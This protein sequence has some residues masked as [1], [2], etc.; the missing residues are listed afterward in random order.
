MLN[1]LDELK[2][3]LEKN[4]LLK[5]EISLNESYKRAI[6]IPEVLKIL[7]LE[8]P[9]VTDLSETLG[10]KLISVMAIRMDLNKRVD[11]HKKFVVAGLI[12]RG[13]LMGLIPN[14]KRDTLIDGGNFNS[15]SALKFYAKRFGMKGMYVMSYLFPDHII[16][17]LEG[18]DFTV[19]K[20]PHQ[21]KYDKMREREFYEFLYNKM[22]EP[23]F[24]KN[25][26]CLWHAKHGGEVEYPFGKELAKKIPASISINCSVSCLG[27]GST[28]EGIQIPIQ[29][30]FKE[31]SLSPPKIFIA[32]HELSPLFVKIM[33]KVEISRDI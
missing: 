9:T 25:K 18:K 20:V 27:A 11:N 33:E 4:G 31:N 17:L 22:R 21:Q 1:L 30:L 16:N 15:A 29:D 19:I 5:K 28:L 12:L 6:K 26:F 8:L 3:I 10:L 7:D 2:D 14:K 24:R 13:V 32:E 23:E